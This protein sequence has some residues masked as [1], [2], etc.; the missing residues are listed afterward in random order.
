MTNLQK[1]FISACEQAKL[2]IDLD[3]EVLVDK[4]LVKSLLRIRG[5]GSP[6]G[7]LIFSS[8]NEIKTIYN[9]LIADGFGFSVF[10]EP[11][12]DTCDFDSFKEIFI[13]WGWSGN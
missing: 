6:N 3:Y 9:S 8:S 2:T 13:D 1:Q 7:M 5:I 10:S 4:I 11:S 12:V